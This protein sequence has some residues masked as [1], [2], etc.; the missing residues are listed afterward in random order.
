M[1][2]DS[3]KLSLPPLSGVKRHLED[4]AEPAPKKTN[5]VTPG[6]GPKKFKKLMNNK[7]K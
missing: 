7:K 4:V 5:D 6:K 1:L 3:I 2:N